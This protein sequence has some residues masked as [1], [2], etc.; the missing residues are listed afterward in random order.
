MAKKVKK[1]TRK[2]KPKL[3]RAPKPK[4]IT[5]GK[6]ASPI[7]KVTTLQDLSKDPDL[8][9]RKIPIIEPIDDAETEAQHWSRRGVISLKNLKSLIEEHGESGGNELFTTE[10]EKYLEKWGLGS[11]ETIFQLSLCSN[12]GRRGHN[13]HGRRRR[14]NSS[15][16]IYREDFR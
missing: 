8:N 7:A 9:P 13:Y 5:P 12:L 15:G 2:S 3:S 1:K 14:K 11:V 4:Q 6:G 16:T 10:V